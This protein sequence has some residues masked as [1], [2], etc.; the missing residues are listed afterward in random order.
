MGEGAK[1]AARLA[2]VLSVVRLRLGLHD[3]TDP[4]TGDHLTAGEMASRAIQRIMRRWA[5]LGVISLVTFVCWVL[6]DATR[7]W[8]NYG[9][10]YAAIVIE[11]IVGMFFFGQS[12][13]DAVIIRRLERL[14]REHGDMLRAIYARVCGDEGEARP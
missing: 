4:V 1:M 6:G 2:T 5:F 7:V 3:A 12:L 11:S 10:S 9:A 14:E 8:W 13:R